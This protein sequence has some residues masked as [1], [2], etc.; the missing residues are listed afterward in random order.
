MFPD[1]TLGVL[2]HVTAFRL[3]PTGDLAWESELGEPSERTMRVDAFDGGAVVVRAGLSGAWSFA[4]DGALRW[5]MSNERTV[6]EKFA[7]LPDGGFV[8][9]LNFFL[10]E[11]HPDRCEGPELPCPNGI[12]LWRIDGDRNVAWEASTDA[13]NWVTDMELAPNGDMVVL[14]ICQ[15]PITGAIS[16]ALMRWGV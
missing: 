16:M 15:A 10:P 4:S 3:T 11:G 12:D 13:C 5:T 14:A 6:V 9:A 7:A 2:G 1:S 8:G